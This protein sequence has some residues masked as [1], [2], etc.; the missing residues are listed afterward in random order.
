MINEEMVNDIKQLF[1]R[2]C[3]G[4]D[5]FHTQR[6]AKMAKH[7]AQ[8]E[9]ADA[10]IAE[11][12]ALLHD[13]D[14]EKLFKAGSNNAERLMTKYGYSDGVKEQVKGIISNISFRGSG[15]NVPQSIEGKAVQDADRL[16]AMGAIGIARAFAYGGYKGRKMYDPN[17]EC[18]ESMDDAEY[19]NRESTTINHFY[20]KLLRIKS[21]MNTRT[22]MEIAEERHE[23]MIRFLEDFYS[24]WNS[25]S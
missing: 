21:M 16:D 10:D 3:T 18:T 12:A 17:I 15:R 1:E 22:A 14:D 9:G 23:R 5:F 2:D 11:L 20:E 4:H 6:V 7:I 8:C 19:R 24:E 13:T 25:K